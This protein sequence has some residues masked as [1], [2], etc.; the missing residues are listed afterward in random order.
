MRR[1][2]LF[3][4]PLAILTASCSLGLEQTA[5]SENTQKEGTALIPGSMIVQFDELTAASIADGNTLT[6][7]TGA[8]ISLEGLGIKSVERLFPDA[9]EWEER[10]R[11]AGLHRWYRIKYDPASQPVTKAADGFAA[12]PGVLYVEP[13]R[14]IRSTSYF[15]DPMAPEQWS[16]Y[17]DGSLGPAYSAGCDLN[18]LPVWSN[19]TTGSSNVIVAVIDEGVQLDHPDLAAACIPG[20]PQ[21][22]K[23]FVHGE[24]G[25][26][27]PGGDHGTHVAGVIGA[28]NDNGVGISGI[29]GGSNGKGGVR[30]LSCA[31]F[32]EDPADPEKTIQ[33]DSYNAMVWAADHGAV[34]ANNSWGYVYDSEADAEKGSVGAMGPAIDYFIQYAGCDKEGN[35]L[36]DSPMKGGVVIFAAGNEG[37]RMAWPAAYDKVISVGALSGKFERAYYSNNGDWVDICAPGGDVK[38]GPMILSTITGGG[39]GNMQG[40]SMA[41]P[42]VSGVA[43]LIVSYFGGP[44]FTNEMLKE[45]LLGGANPT[46][47]PL[48]LK[49]GPLVDALGSMT[50][51]GTI[52]PG[53]V[54]DVSL[55]TKSNFVTAEWEVTADPD[56]VAA[57]GFLVAA[58][59]DR[60]VIEGADPR[61]L[62]SS[63]VKAVVETGT[64]SVGERISTT[65][66]GLDFDTD[67]FVTVTA[68]DYNGNYAEPSAVY[69][70]HTEVNNPPV[71]A[72]DYTGDFR[73]R[74]FETLYVSFS[75]SDPDGHAVSVVTET[76]SSALTFYDEEGGISARIV[77]KN[78]PQGRY[79]ARITATDS[80][81]ATATR[82]IEYEILENHPPKVRKEMDNIMLGGS[83]ESR[84]IDM[85]EYVADEDGES[86]A[87]TIATSVQNVVH[88]NPSGDR[89][90][91]TALGYGLTDVTITATDAAGATCQIVFKVLVRDSSRP[92]DIFPNP[93]KTTLTVLPGGSG[94]L[95]YR[96]SNKAGAV[97]RSGKA[98]VSPFEPLSLDLGDLAAGTYY[99][100]LKGAGLNDTYTIVKI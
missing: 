99:L 38:K 65:L 28:V 24:G 7:A 89:V 15:N 45:R 6:K 48:Y 68:F 53:Q 44:G 46:K 95:E 8:G 40:T 33:G 29:A 63:V 31:I 94:E 56:D 84:V 49:I 18:I 87:Y 1:A 17:N 5:G 55:S 42:Q 73:L 71:I 77:G 85:S 92:V 76:G 91:M 21:G 62:P 9:G 70:V 60:E 67:Y 26:S 82:Q 12:L 19:F 93:V 22:S 34:I 4:I 80:F 64:A 14:R 98:T 50:Y 30:I 32:M 16:L 10:H 66:S 61:K 59:K 96:L 72:T 57:F 39:Y 90:T 100:Y 3:F 35:Q 58:S 25:Y 75:V 11:A 51:G 54:D 23:S 20:G 2:L 86:L 47:V 36:P 97:V 52:P 79:S 81:G 74:P 69:D 78:A 27:F 41:C 83:G 37:Y 43:A 88:L 13:E